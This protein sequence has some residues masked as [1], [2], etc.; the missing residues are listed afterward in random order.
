MYLIYHVTTL[1][2]PIERSS[3]CLGGSTLCYLTMLKNLVTISILMVEIYHVT[4][5]KS[6]HEFMGGSPS[7]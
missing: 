2:H 4:K 5:L 6:L 7:R 3:K 1:D